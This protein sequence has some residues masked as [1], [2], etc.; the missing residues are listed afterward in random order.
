MKNKV[1]PHVLLS[2]AATEDLDRVKLLF[3]FCTLKA[4]CCRERFI[5]WAGILPGPPLAAVITSGLGWDAF[6]FS[7]TV[8]TPVPVRIQVYTELH[9][10]ERQ[11]SCWRGQQE[12]AGIV[13]GDLN[14][15]K[16]YFFGILLL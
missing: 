12:E 5:S 13:S 8:K 14:T 1:A 10:E 11:H 3:C 6:F 15:N 7:P 16:I 2:P 9:T 4:F